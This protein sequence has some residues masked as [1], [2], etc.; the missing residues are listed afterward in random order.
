MSIETRIR[1]AVVIMATEVPADKI[2]LAD[3]AERAGVSLPS[4]R[5]HVGGKKGLLDYMAAHEIETFGD[6][7]SMRHRILDAARV[8]FSRQDLNTASLDDIAKQAGVTKGAIYHHF[9]HKDALLLSLSEQRVWRFL[10]RIL[11]IAGEM[12]SVWTTPRS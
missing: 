2:L 9:K 4:V 1:G 7:R 11:A 3:I 5:K 12:D 6:T 10:G 8:V